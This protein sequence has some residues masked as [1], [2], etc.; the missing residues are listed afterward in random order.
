MGGLLRGWSGLVLHL[1]YSLEIMDGWGS[2]RP[3][4]RGAL[5]LVVDMPLWSLT[6]YGPHTRLG[7]SAQGERAKQAGTRSQSLDSS[8][9]EESSTERLCMQQ[10]VLPC[11]PLCPTP[12]CEAGLGL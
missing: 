9:G 5:F 7:I 11:P 2:R 12:Q 1:S 8:G 10:V 3:G 4:S 6:H